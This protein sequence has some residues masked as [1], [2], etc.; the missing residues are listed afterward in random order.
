[1]EHLPPTAHPTGGQL[2]FLD[3]VLVVV[4]ADTAS[5]VPESDVLRRLGRLEV[6]TVDSDGESWTGRYFF[7]RLTYVEI[8]GPDDLADAEPGHTG[9]GLSTRT[10]GSLAAMVDRAADAGFP[11]VTGRRTGEEDGI[12]VPWFDYAES[13]A[14]DQALEVWGME[15]LRD[16][17]DLRRRETHYLEWT[18]ASGKDGRDAPILTEV[19]HVELGVSVEDAVRA[20]QILDAAGFTVTSTPDVVLAQDTH[21]TIRLCPVPAS[22]AGVRRIGFNL[23]AP[24]R[25]MSV[26]RIGRSL[27]TLG[28]GAHAEWTFSTPAS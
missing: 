19:T 6:A 1:M 8:F 17:D 16:P 15:Y 11:L 12:A 22:D 25:D 5:A 26:H 4:D 21:T 14:S 28:P 10:R 18:A 20:S 27:F 23:T 2:A 9:L 24:T 7:G 13:G 3:H